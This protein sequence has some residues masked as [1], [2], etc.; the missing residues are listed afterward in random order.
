MTADD[1]RLIEDSLPIVAISAARYDDKAA[2]I[3]G[4]A[5]GRQS[6]R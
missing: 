2:A 6:A 3:P 4:T 1:R 5:A